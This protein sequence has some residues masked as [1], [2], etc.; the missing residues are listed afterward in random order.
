MSPQEDPLAKESGEGALARLLVPALPS[1]R[2]LVILAI[3]FAFWVALL[4]LLYFMTV[5]PVHK[6][7]EPDRLTSVTPLTET[8]AGRT[9]FCIAVV[10]RF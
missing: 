3:V 6:A 9:V 5:G 10:S 2:R 8:C 1:K 7:Q 4:L